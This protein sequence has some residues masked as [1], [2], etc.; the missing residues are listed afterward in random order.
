MKTNFF[1]AAA[2]LILTAAILAAPVSSARAQSGADT[3]Q[4]LGNK[5]LEG[6]KAKNKDALKSLIHPQVV[7]FMKD[8]NP[9]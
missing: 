9:G 7:T 6:I 8:G 2:L 4:I 3:P 5:I 1:Y